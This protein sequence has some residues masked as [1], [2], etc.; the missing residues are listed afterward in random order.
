MED[1]LDSE[2]LNRL[3]TFQGYG[4]PGGEFWFVGMEEQGEGTALELRWRLTFGVIEDLKAA[5][6]RRENFRAGDRFN[7]ERLIPT[8]ATMCKIV[9]RLKGAADWTNRDEIRRYQVARLGQLNGETFLTEVLPL[10][11]RNTRHWPDDSPI[12]T[13]EQYECEVRPRRIAKLREL[14][15]QHA[16]RYV[17]C[18]GKANWEYHRSIFPDVSFEP[19]LNGRVLLGRNQYSV[20][21]L[22]PFFAYYLTTNELIDGIAGAIEALPRNVPFASL[23]RSGHPHTAR[24]AEEILHDDWGRARRP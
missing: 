4:N 8:W 7:P 17:F 1:R 12:H 13:R 16:P 22:T 3:L 9:L 20:I 19:V 21:A 15:A 24:D 5:Q 23:G 2:D 14:Y 6:E 18:Y 11:A 10:P